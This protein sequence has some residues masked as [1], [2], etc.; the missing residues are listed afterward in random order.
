MPKVK[1]FICKAAF[2]KG[3]RV[4][5]GEVIVEVSNNRRVS[6]NSRVG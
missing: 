2:V 6:N 5:W 4:L 1:N 3:V